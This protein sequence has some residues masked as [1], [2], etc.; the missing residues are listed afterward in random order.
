MYMDKQLLFSEGQ[1]LETGVSENIIDLGPKGEAYDPLF[2]VVILDTP[3]SGNLE[4]KVETSVT[5]DFATPKT[6]AT[7]KGTEGKQHAV[8]E[9]FPRGAEKYVRLTYTT[10]ATG[11]VTAGL[12][13]DVDTP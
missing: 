7:F 9:R 4:V 3:L 13:L 6:L 8:K 1:T 11:K 5:E 2:L 10:G 12:V